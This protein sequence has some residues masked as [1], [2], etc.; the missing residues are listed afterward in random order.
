MS[1]K[2]KTAV[3]EII[4]AHMDGEDK[5]TKAVL[6]DVMESVNE[7]EALEQEPCEKC[8]YSTKDGYCQYDDI[9]ET[10]SPLEPCDDAIS[11]DAVCGALLDYW[12]DIQFVDGSGYDVYEDCKAIIDELPPVTQ[13]SGKWIMTGEVDVY[14]DLP[15]Y[16]CSKCGHT[17]L[18]NGDYCPNCGCRMVEP[19]ES[20]VEKLKPCINYEDGC[21]EWAGCP[22]V[23]YKAESEAQ[24]E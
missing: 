11:R 20:D 1:E 3:M 12:H 10:I 2:I 13:K 18:E 5:N 6:S 22:C 21:E 17:S 15:S 14:Y 24:T 16:E 9:S 7:L 4:K 19:Q 8:V 23:H